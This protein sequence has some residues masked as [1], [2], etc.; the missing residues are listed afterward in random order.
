MRRPTSGS[1]KKKTIRHAGILL[2]PTSL[3]GPHGVGDLGPA[4]HRFLRTLAGLGMDLWQMLPLGP[5]G[6]GDSPYQSL[7][8][9]AG[10]PLLVSLEDLAA[11]GLLDEADLAGM[12]TFPPDHVD[13]GAV[14]PAR[15]AAL[16]RAA[17][18][19]ALRAPARL[20][21]QAD[22]FRAAEHGWLDDF[23]L[24]ASLKREQAGRPWFEWPGALVQREPAALAEARLRL[25]DEMDAEIL[26]QFFFDR[27]WRR[28]RR[29]AHGLGIRLVGDLP[30]FVA[31]DSA[32]VWAHPE[33]FH[34]DGRGRPTVVAGVPPDYFSATGQLWGNPLYR[35][36]AHAADGYAW[37]RARMR[38]TAEWV[39]LVRL[40]HFRGF[41]SYWEIPAGETTAIHGRWV[42]AP[43]GELLTALREEL[44]KLPILAEDLGI[45]T[46]EVDALRRRFHLPGM[47]VL[48]FCTWL[49]RE[50]P[51]QAPEACAPDCVIYTGT[52]D[53]DTLKGW[54]TGAPGADHTLSPEALE[55]ERAVWKDYLHAHTP[56]ALHWAFI[57]LAWRSP[58][59]YAI[60]PWQDVL[61]LGSAARM[62][63]PGTSQGNWQ[64]RFTDAQVPAAACETLAALNRRHARGRP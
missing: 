41:E 15:L 64:W 24:F 11:E 53:N 46:P 58:A 49:L 3:P 18:R 23:A 20:R 55:A 17:S 59:R 37:W 26:I 61:E 56:E 44:G 34:L 51:P 40:D 28:L 35:W 1:A 33:L 31:H 29:A 14:I 21:K 27:Q 36:E 48:Q 6:Y 45:I 63:R 25:K 39:D 60:L 8:T 2:H 62:N 7:S 5:T 50:Q 9:F 54:L 19:F 42:K 16:R 10:N 13:F 38:R 43:G 52:H 57:E 22:A 32:D 12:D 4:A 30:I 47:R